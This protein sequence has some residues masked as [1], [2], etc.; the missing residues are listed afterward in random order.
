MTYKYS[1]QMEEDFIADILRIDASVFDESALGTDASIRSRYNANKDC[2]ILAYDNTC[3]NNSGKATI[4][5]YIAFFPITNDLS[6][7]MKTENKTFDDD[8]CDSD[9]L[10]TYDNNFDF[11][12][13][14]ISAAVSP[15][16]QGRGIGAT[17]SQKCRSFLNSKAKS[18]SRIRNLF[19]YA[20]TEGGSRLLTGAG[21]SAI[22][23]QFEHSHYEGIKLMQY[24]FGGQTVV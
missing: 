18:G 16:Y 24:S 6:H 7:R 4:V 21:F 1:G 23:K 22:E 14:L 3:D 9:I 11:D 20:Y 5:G 17:L 19:A 12:V 10:P 8:I 15:E 13:F 2:F